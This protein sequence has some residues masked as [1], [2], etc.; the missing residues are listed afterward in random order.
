MSDL[1]NLKQQ[2][3][4]L[5]AGEKPPRAREA[6]KKLNISEAEYVALSCGESVYALN[7]ELLLDLFKQL[8]RLGEVMALTRNDAVVLEHHGIY[9]NPIIK[10]NHIIINEPDMDLR[11]KVSAWKYAFAVDEGGRQ[12]FQFFDIFGQAVHKIYMTKQSNLQTYDDLVSQFTINCDFEIMN[13]QKKLTAASL[14]ASILNPEVNKKAIQQD[15]LTLDNPHQIDALFQSYGL[16]R[17]Q[18]YRYLTDAAIPLQKNA[19]QPVL[20]KS[21]ENNWSLLMFVPNDSATQIHN[22]SVHKL[23]T[24]GP[25]FNVLDPKFNMHANLQLIT[26]TWLVVKNTNGESVPSVELFDTEGKAV[27]M[28]Y[29]HPNSRT[30]EITKQWKDFLFSQKLEGTNK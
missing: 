19:L 23:L 14:P 7:T 28:V 22:G 29:L 3:A 1:F 26:E 20:E 11:L 17:P 15:W 5:L 27:M 16:T 2:K 25:W 24:M 12:S 10:Q 13:V 8:H 6:A 9:S 21:A 30:S 18:A 4:E